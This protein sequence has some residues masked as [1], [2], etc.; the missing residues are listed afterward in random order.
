MSESNNYFGEIVTVSAPGVKVSAVEDTVTLVDASTTTSTWELT[1]T[2]TAIFETNATISVSE[3][4]RVQDGTQFGWFQS[5]TSNT[6]NLMPT[7]E[8][9]VGMTMVHPAPPP[10]GIY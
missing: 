1:L 2:N 8:V 9:S 4:T 5:F 10:P 7:E 6:F 3:P